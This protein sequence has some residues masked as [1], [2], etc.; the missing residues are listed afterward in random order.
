MATSA[1]LERKV[2]VLNTRPDRET[3]GFGASDFVLAVRDA[4]NAR[5]GNAEGGDEA[6][7]MRHASEYMCVAAPCLCLHLDKRS[8]LLVAARTS[9]TS[10]ARECLS[11]LMLSRCVAHRSQTQ[12][13][14]MG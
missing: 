4:L 14:P 9:S 3:L 1:R 5:Y 13:W 7:A 6:P 11:T 8:G 2:L 10:E 12:L